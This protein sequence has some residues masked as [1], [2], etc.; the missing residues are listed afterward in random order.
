VRRILLSAKLLTGYCCI[1]IKQDD[2]A[3]KSDDFFVGG[4]MPCGIG[5]KGSVSLGANRLG[6]KQSP[7]NRRTLD[8]EAAD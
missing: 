4:Y 2:D 5:E 1:T 8:P 6:I 7:E 3:Q